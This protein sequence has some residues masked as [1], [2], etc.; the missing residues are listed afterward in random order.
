MNKRSMSVC[1]RDEWSALLLCLMK[2]T[3]AV[4]HELGLSPEAVL[5]CAARHLQFRDFASFASSIHGASRAYDCC[6]RR[7][8]VSA[9]DVAYIKTLAARVDSERDVLACVPTMCCPLDLQYHLEAPPL[10]YEK[11]AAAIQ[12]LKDDVQRTFS[13]GGVLGDRAVEDASSFGRALTAIMSTEDEIAAYERAVTAIL[14]VRFA[15]QYPPVDVDSDGSESE[16]ILVDDAHSRVV[17]VSAAS[18]GGR[19]Q[20]VKDVV[21]HPLGVHK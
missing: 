8:S 20:R 18:A 17:P 6:M 21:N 4:A 11:V 7:E 10:A 12:A 13:Q 5:D 14:K 2:T 15:A 9:M 16:Q 19:M 3:L 1:R